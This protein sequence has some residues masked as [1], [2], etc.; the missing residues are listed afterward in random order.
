MYMRF[1]WDETQ[2]RVNLK[3]HEIDFV[4]A[5]RVFA[6]LTVTFE[7]IGTLIM[8]NASL[9]WDCWMEIQYR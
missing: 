4:D 8:S 6:G 3:D 7:T 5:E 2:R 1:T 9:R